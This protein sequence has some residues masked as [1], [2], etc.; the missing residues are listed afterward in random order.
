MLGKRN[1]FL[2]FVPFLN[3]ISAW[4]NIILRLITVGL[5]NPAI[6]LHF[7]KPSFDFSYL[8]FS[9]FLYCRIFGLNKDSN[10]FSCW[11]CSNLRKPHVC[12]WH[13]PH[14][15]QN[16]L[17]FFCASELICLDAFIYLIFLI[18]WM[19]SLSSLLLANTNGGYFSLQVLFGNWSVS[20]NFT[21]TCRCLSLG[22]TVAVE[23]RLVARIHYKLGIR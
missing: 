22:R 5:L 7:W 16:Y 14:P 12:C 19:F 18:L 17:N 11:P 2:P 15:R 6:V 1:T 20:V 3:H 23:H 13:R 8:L 9:S 21:W 4:R 10:I